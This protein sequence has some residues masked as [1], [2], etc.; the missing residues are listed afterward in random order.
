MN[1]IEFKA[2]ILPTMEE[3]LLHN[4]PT[5]IGWK[6]NNTA[7]RHLIWNSETLNPFHHIIQELIPQFSPEF[8]AQIRKCSWLKTG[9]LWIQ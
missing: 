4:H 5:T 8:Q 9:I 2:A 6:W 7:I 1:W 3:L